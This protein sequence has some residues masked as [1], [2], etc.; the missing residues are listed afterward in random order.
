MD[1]SR[2]GGI[3]TERST[4]R[5][6]VLANHNDGNSTFSSPVS[7]AVGTNPTGLVVSDFTNDGLLDIVVANQNDDTLY[8]LPFLK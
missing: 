7:F 6:Q 1:G 3:A 2:P 4:N 5:V 8:L